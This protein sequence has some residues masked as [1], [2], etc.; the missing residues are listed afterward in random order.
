M[1]LNEISL[2]F[3]V[4]KLWPNDDDDDDRIDAVYECGGSCTK[5][6]MERRTGRKGTQREWKNW[7]R[8]NIQ[9]YVH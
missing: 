2:F 9:Q 5:I 7:G 6:K 1:P 4:L 3:H 8:R